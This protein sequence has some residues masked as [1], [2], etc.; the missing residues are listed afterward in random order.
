MVKKILDLGPTNKV[1]QRVNGSEHSSNHTRIWSELSGS[2]ARS[3]NG[4][5]ERQ[6]ER[7]PNDTEQQEIERISMMR[8]SNAGSVRRNVAGASNSCHPTETI[9]AEKTR[10]GEEPNSHG[11]SQHHPSNWVDAD[12]HGDEDEE[13]E[14]ELYIQATPPYYEE[15]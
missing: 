2:A 8:I 14:N 11:W 7:N 4:V 5:E 10:D 1:G 12:E 9:P 6:G 3:S 15:Q 13:E